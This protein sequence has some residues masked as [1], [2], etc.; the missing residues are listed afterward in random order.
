[1]QLAGS[2]V[3]SCVMVSLWRFS[4]F[5]L[6][7]SLTQFLVSI[8]LPPSITRY[9]MN[10]TQSVLFPHSMMCM[11]LSMSGKCVFSMTK[12]SLKRERDTHTQTCTS[13]S[14]SLSLSSLFLWHPGYL[15]NLVHHQLYVLWFY[16]VV[17]SSQLSLTDSI[18][19]FTRVEFE[20]LLFLASS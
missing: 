2:I 15:D 12:F 1:M 19:W 6:S 9:K 17:T 3:T 8:E 16:S 18:N 10:V 7:S 20:S 14:L 5:H 11:I 13:L 4:S